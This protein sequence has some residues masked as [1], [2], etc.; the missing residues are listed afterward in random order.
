M[1]NGEE[2][3]M[4][5]CVV[6]V[7]VVLPNWMVYCELVSWHRSVGGDQVTLTAPRVVSGAKE[8]M[9][10]ESTAAGESGEQFWTQT[11]LHL[12]VY[13]QMTFVYTYVACITHTPSQVVTDVQSL[14]VPLPLT[15]ALTKYSCP[16]FGPCWMVRTKVCW[17]V[18]WEWKWSSH[19]QWSTV[20]WSPHTGQLEEI[21]WLWL[22]AMTLTRC[23][24]G[25]PL[26]QGK[27]HTLSSTTLESMNIT[28]LC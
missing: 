3:G 7:E 18:W 19:T 27:W 12:C 22:L 14:K 28:M 4:L 13:W 16:T 5:G 15:A 2:E 17:G 24:R 10:R 6:G 21:R 1:L 20:G 9:C 11:Q 23:L 26:Q 8:T 25:H